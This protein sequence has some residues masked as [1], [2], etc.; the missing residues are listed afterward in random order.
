MRKE[1]IKSPNMADALIYCVSLIGEIH[2]KQDLQYF[3]QPQ[4]SKEDSLLTLA[5]LH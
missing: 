5:G 3:R 1:G 2:Y 4:Y